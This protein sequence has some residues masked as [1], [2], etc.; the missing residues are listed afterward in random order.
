SGAGDAKPKQFTLAPS[1]A[2]TGLYEVVLS[3]QA[4]GDH[5][6][7]VVATKDGKELGRQKLKFTVIPPADEMLKLAANPKLLAAVAEQSHGFHYPL[8]QFPE[9][10]DQLI[11]SDPHA[12]GPQ[13]RSVPLSNYVR[14]AAAVIGGADPTW[15]RKYDLP[16]QGAIVVTLLAAEW[17]LR[18]RWQ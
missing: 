16:M 9:L 8:G 3:D 18:R 11:R 17:L 12:T 10:I 5:E 4:K 13:Q 1:D 2:H 14:I 7:E 6:I 15:P